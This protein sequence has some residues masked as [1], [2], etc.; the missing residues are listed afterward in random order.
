MNKANAFLILITIFT[1]VTTEAQHLQSDLQGDFSQRKEQIMQYLQTAVADSMVITGQHCGNGNATKQGYYDYVEGLFQSTGKYPALIGLEYGYSPGNNL[2]LINS[3]AKRHAKK[4]GLVTIT[5]H[6]DNPWVEG[7]NCRWNSI[8][9]KETINFT[10]LVKDAPDSKEKA[11]YRNELLKVGA[12]LQELQEAGIVVLWR[13]FHEM[14]GSWFWW[15]PDE[16]KS[17]RNR[18]EYRLL[19]KDMYDT[20]TTGL[21]L[22]NLIWIYS[23]IA[24]G[25]WSASVDAFYPGN[26]MV[27]INGVDIYSNK[28]EFKDYDLIR[29]LGKPVVVGEIGPV[30]EA[31]GTFDALETLQQLRGKA[32]WFLQWSSWPNAKVA[33]VDNPNAREMMNHPAAV[34]LENL[35]LNELKNQ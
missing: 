29:A 2:S 33:I 9:N 4:G 7:Y 31:Y 26:E 17:P 18:E 19:W 23:P 21:K 3:F 32:A 25:E 35:G 10:K 34:T 13:P 5:W 14:N 30:K 20:F 27:D 28:P 8:E 6:A 22:D 15:G 11:S 16:L 12:A 24:S 1:A